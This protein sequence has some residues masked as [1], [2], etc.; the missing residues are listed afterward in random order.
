M[1]KTWYF[2]TPA[3]SQRHLP[4]AQ[5]PFEKLTKSKESEKLNSAPRKTICSRFKIECLKPIGN[6]Y[7]PRPAAR[8]SPPNPFINLIEFIGFRK[9]AVLHLAEPVRPRPPNQE[10]QWIEI[11]SRTNGILGISYDCAESQKS[12]TLQIVL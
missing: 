5:N 9:P 6:L 4:R 3:G 2:G 1:S 10:I 12:L 7:Y 8:T 11:A